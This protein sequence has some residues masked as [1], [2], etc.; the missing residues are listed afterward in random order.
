MA[1]VGNDD[2]DNTIIIA[3]KNTHDSKVPVSIRIMDMEE[4]IDLVGQ[5][6]MAIHRKGFDSAL[7][8]IIK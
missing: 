2:T 1:T 4:V 8:K 7:Q 5:L 6:M 3:G